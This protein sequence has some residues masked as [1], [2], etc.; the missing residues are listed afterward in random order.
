MA[1]DAGFKVVAHMMPDLPNVGWERDVEGF[2]VRDGVESFPLQLFLV[3]DRQMCGC[4]VV[5]VFR[6][7]RLSYGWTQDLSDTGDSRHR[8][9][10]ALEDRPVQ[11]LPSG[12]ARRARGEAAGAGAA[13]DSSLPH[14]AVCRCRRSGGA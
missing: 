7:S 10:R 8:L 9:V 5:G 13:L 4:V 3:A 11:E 1:K 14:P 12:G 2:K 6:E